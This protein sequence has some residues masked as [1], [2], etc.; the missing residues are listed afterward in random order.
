MRLAMS[1][2]KDA[3]GGLGQRLRRAL[4]HQRRPV[5]VQPSR[6]PKV[7]LMMNPLRR[8]IFAELCRNPCLPS[9]EL[10][11]SLKTSRANINWH[12]DKLV[13]G[14][15]ISKIK[16][17]GRWAYQPINFLSDE[18]LPQFHVLAK[19]LTR[20]VF[21]AVRQRP[22][23]TQA[24][25]SKAVGL[26]RQDLAWHLGKLSKASLIKTVLDGRFRRYKASTL[27]DE[28]AQ[29]HSKRIGR[30]KRSLIVA[31]RDDN[32]DPTIVKSLSS[33]LLIRISCG[34]GSCVIDVVTDPY[35]HILSTQERAKKLTRKE[36]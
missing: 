17:G 20:K 31:F 1:Q 24:K 12:L 33:S 6:D 8:A 4:E 9:G 32:T 18:E 26:S 30:F 22:G 25:L 34:E 16:V 21:R 10:A 7:S 14:H 35:H 2:R 23:I 13:Q 11:Q 29:V 5:L 36:K 28:L 27:L 19:A 3:E 15:F